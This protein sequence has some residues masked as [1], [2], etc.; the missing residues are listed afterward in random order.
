MQARKGKGSRQQ[1]YAGPSIIP[2]HFEERGGGE[3]ELMGK[4]IILLA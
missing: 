3:S 1:G 4:A 2:I